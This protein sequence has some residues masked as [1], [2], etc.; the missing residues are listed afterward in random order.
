MK[1]EPYLSNW[2]KKYARQRIIMFQDVIKIVGTLLEAMLHG[3]N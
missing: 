1:S 3:P 2:S